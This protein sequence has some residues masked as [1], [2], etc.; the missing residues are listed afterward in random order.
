MPTTDTTKLKSLSSVTTA[1]V[2]KLYKDREKQLHEKVDATRDAYFGF[3]FPINRA[4]LTAV[5]QAF[6]VNPE[7]SQL[8]SHK[9][10][11]FSTFK[12]AGRNRGSLTNH[13]YGASILALRG[14]DLDTGL[15]SVT[16]TTLAELVREQ[17]EV[18]LEI[19]EVRASWFGRMYFP[20]VAFVNAISVF[21]G[22]VG[23]DAVYEV[24]T[25]YGFSAVA[26]TRK[27]VR[28][29]FGI[30]LWLTLLARAK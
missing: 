11:A 5:S 2:E 4:D 30:A 19:A 13:I 24:A 21:G 16:D 29:D 23:E 9:G 17:E 8:L 14:K 6:G 25:K 3:I 7:V 22:K 12:I 10:R 18:I 26:G 28:G 15:N 27:E 1:D 20:A